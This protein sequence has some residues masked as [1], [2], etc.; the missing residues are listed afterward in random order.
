MR[1]VQDEDVAGWIN[2]K[3]GL[4]QALDLLIAG[5]RHCVLV[6]EG[7]EYHFTIM[8]LIEQSYEYSEEKDKPGTIAIS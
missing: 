5:K 1:L 7:S 6:A 3:E 8:H 2:T 4:T